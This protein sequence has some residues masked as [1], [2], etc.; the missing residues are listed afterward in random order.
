MI[1]L[2]CLIPALK[3]RFFKIMTPEIPKSVEIERQPW[4]VLVSS[5]DFN[6]I[7]GGQESSKNLARAW[8]NIGIKTCLLSPFPL[9]D[10]WPFAEAITL[11]TVNL[12][13]SNNRI[14]LVTEDFNRVLNEL[15]PRAIILTHPDLFICRLFLNMNEAWQKR[16]SAIWRG[17]VN[18]APSIKEAI[19]QSARKPKDQGFRK[20]RSAL[21]RNLLVF[22]Q[23]QA[24]RRVKTNIAVS[25]AVASS[26]AGIGV[27]K[28]KITVCPTQ[29]G[30]EFS[31]EQR[32]R[33]GENWRRRF[34]KP[35]ELGILMVGRLSPDKKIEWALSVFAYLRQNRRY[36]NPGGHF[37][38]LKMMAVGKPAYLPY[39][40]QL[41]KEKQRI[42]EETKSLFSADSVT[43]DFWG[44]ADK[45]TL[46]GLYNAY[47]FLL[48][49]SLKEG[50]PRVLIE[51]MQAGMPVIGRRDCSAV[52][53]I[54]ESPPYSVGYLTSSPEDAGRTILKIM[55]YPYEIIPGLKENA[56]R[57]GSCFDA[58]KSA[59]KVFELITT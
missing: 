43:F 36:L 50:C 2:G 28:Q 8:Q 30:G 46:Q 10:P 6:Q 3:S 29:V 23:S 34:L 15:N 5:Y 27:E 45:P 41:I 31:P 51:A 59:L 18:P 21:F 42:E 54:L 55:T 47:D 26:L 4:I 19:L 13:S 38:A 40:E 33:Y 14:S 57:W 25:K 58:E 52:Q 37:R 11:P 53:E 12:L 17:M 16:T 39:M 24:A 35:D 44:P 49:S 56:L 7:G 48:H 20:L 9:E 32:L 22:L 1:E